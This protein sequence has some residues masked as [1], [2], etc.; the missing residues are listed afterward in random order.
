MRSWL[1]AA[2]TALVTLAGACGGGSE[3]T[4]DAKAFCQQLDRLAANDPFAAFGD[5]ATDEEVSTAF[6]ALVARAGA[7]RHVAPAEAR[8]SAREYAEAA[9]ALQ[10]LLAA[11]DFDGTKVD[12]RAYRDQQLRYTKAA[13]LLERYLSNECT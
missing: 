13:A 6:D 9:A 5:R 8:A 11:A 7:L 4:S 10:R 1:A 12:A 2:L 3:D